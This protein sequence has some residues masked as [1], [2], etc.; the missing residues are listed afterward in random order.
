MKALPVVLA[1]VYLYL[2]SDGVTGD[3][4]GYWPSGT[5]R[6][7]SALLVIAP[8]CAACAAW[9]VGRL[10]RGGVFDFPGVRA[11]GQAV[12]RSTWP[13]A[14]L[15]VTG[16]A[17]SLAMV[18]TR[19]RAVAGSPDLRVLG[20]GAAVLAGHVAVGVVLGRVLSP[21]VAT[22][23]CL[24][25]SYAWLVYP[26]SVL[27]F[28]IR[29]LT[30]FDTDCCQTDSRIATWGVLAPA[31]IGLC[32]VAGSV[33]VFATRK[34]RPLPFVAA[35]C[36]VTSGV[37]VA[38][39]GVRQFGVD[40]VQP[41]AERALVCGG[42]GPVVCVWPEHRAALPDVIQSAASVTRALA[43]LGI[44]TPSRASESTTDGTSWVFAVSA[45]SSASER[46]AS[47]SGALIPSEGPAC[48]PPHSWRGGMSVPLLQAWLEA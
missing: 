36:V 2:E 18:A 42:N 30:G 10:R 37:L 9:E 17:V 13:V 5:L 44:V 33:L 47:I 21:V 20:M 28:S 11:P 22:P 12:L 6:A 19:L 8:V 3:L 16:L 15:G 48:Q 24:L 39:H 38:V 1:L 41:R 43:G 35:G 46:A 34:P 14:L 29:H 7:V 40:A 45:V 26:P 32:L 25:G 23:T 31:V 4:D 27:P